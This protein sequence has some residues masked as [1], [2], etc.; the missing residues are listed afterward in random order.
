MLNATLSTSISTQVARPG[1]FIQASLTQPI[2]LQ[3][4][5]IPAG[6]VLEGR[7]Q[8][9]KSGGFLAR[10]GRL[11]LKFDHMRTPSGASA[12]MASHIVGSIGKYDQ[13]AN[14]SE[15]FAGENMKNKMGQTLVRTAIGAGAGAALGTAVGAIAG[16]GNAKVNFNPIYGPTYNAYNPYGYNPYGGMAPVAYRTNVRSG[17]A[18]G[19]GRGAWSGAAIGGGVGLAN[20]LILRTGKDVVIPNGTPLQ[21]QLDAPINLNRHSQVGAS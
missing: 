11:T 21:L 13:I 4:G 18:L 14:G 6:T 19:A 3:D 8:E 16:R 12:P 1:D 2:Y 20:G 17:A 15:T 5:V 10:S 9:A 7:V